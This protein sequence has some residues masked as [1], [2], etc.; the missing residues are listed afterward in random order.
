MH[1]NE[2][3]RTLWAS[4]IR[5]ALT[6]D[7]KLHAWPSERL[8]DYHR[9]QIRKNRQQIVEFLNEAHQKAQELTELAMLACEYWGDGAEARS[10]MMDQLREVPPHLTDDLIQHF[11]KQYPRKEST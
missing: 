4:G 10:E 11:T 7:G 1:A 6:D 5:L 8:K 2:V 9:E 3:L